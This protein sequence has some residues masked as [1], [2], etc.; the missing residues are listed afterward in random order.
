MMISPGALKQMIESPKGPDAARAYEPTEP[1]VLCPS[2][3]VRLYVD[4][5]KYGGKLVK[6]PSC[7]QPMVIPRSADEPA[8]KPP[9]K[10]PAAP[11]TE[12]DAG[13]DEA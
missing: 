5:K 3:K 10:P 6:C 13:E 2:C 9:K 1:I 11:A 8:Q 7:N 4:R 12:D